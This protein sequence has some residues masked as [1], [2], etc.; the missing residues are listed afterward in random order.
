MIFIYV[1]TFVFTM[2]DLHNIYI[3]YIISFLKKTG[4]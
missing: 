3:V 4:F 2:I 1:F